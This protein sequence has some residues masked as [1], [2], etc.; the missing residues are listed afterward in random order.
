MVSTLD[1][2]RRRRRQK[3]HSSSR[4]A[5]SGGRG[6]RAARLRCAVGHCGLSLLLLARFAAARISY[7]LRAGAWPARMLGV[8]LGMMGVAYE[9]MAEEIIHVPSLQKAVAAARDK[10]AVWPAQAYVILDAVAA[11]SPSSWNRSVA[12]DAR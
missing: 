5:A 11:R 12:W 7:R 10:G 6:A 8:L 3:P 9:Q 2:R 1:E 4:A